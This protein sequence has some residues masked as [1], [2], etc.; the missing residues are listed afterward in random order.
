[1]TRDVN[2]IVVYANFPITPTPGYISFFNEIFLNNQYV[3]VDVNNPKTAEFAISLNH[4]ESNLNRI[5][6]SNIPKSKRVLIMFECKQILPEMHKPE[7]LSQYGLIFSPSPYWA[8][9]FNPVMFHYPVHLEKPA[10]VSPLSTRKYQFGIVQ[11]NN[12]SCIK[13]EL[14]SLRRQLIRN[15]AGDLQVRG[16]GWNKSKLLQVYNYCKLVR[17]Y[18]RNLKLTEVNLV[19]RHLIKDSRFL[20]VVDKQ[21]FLESVKVAII[22]ENGSGYVSEKLFDCFRAGTVPIYVG[23]SLSL[24]GVPEECVIR[25]N[26]KV[27]D[28]IEVMNSIY[29]HNLEAIKASG[30]K[31]L[32]GEGQAWSDDIAMRDLAKKIVNAIN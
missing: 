30:F 4:T 6:D 15:F 18:L 22:I 3:C 21:E 2:K 26:P 20:P 14:Y 9:G 24:F 11:R 7:V 13:G 17:Y 31:F 28:L 32:N 5:V 1:M 23:P 27:E 29:K 12:L 10:S 8:K 16:E 25:S 19:P